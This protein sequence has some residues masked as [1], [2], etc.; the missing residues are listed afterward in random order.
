MNNT[1]KYKGFAARVD[2]SADDDVF[3][4]RLLGID[5]IVTFHAET[6]DELR[7]KMVGMV[8]FYIETCEKAGKKPKKNYN[9]KLLFRVPSELHEEIE[10]AAAK[11]G[12][13]INE[14]G[15]EVFES[16]VRS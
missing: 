1:L 11:R 12:K 3:V 14:W 5:D 8:D 6:V 2:F 13:S 16:A 15:K 7:E 4:G 10:I 9:G